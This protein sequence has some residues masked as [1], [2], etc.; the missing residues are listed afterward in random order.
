MTF[1][2][3][4]VNSLMKKTLL[5]LLSLYSVEFQS[6]KAFLTTHDTTRHLPSRQFQSRHRGK[7]FYL[8]SIKNEFIGGNNKEYPETLLYE[9]LRPSSKC[10]PTQ[11]SPTSLAYIG[12]SVFELFV[13]SKYVWPSRR[14]TDL[15]NIVVAKVRGK[16]HL[17]LSVGGFMP[18]RHLFLKI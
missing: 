11:M 14:T 8:S 15:Q 1:D 5:T 18:T 16:N 12:D 17:C 10:D 7:R 4:M 13:R 9:L 6:V 2:C 3:N